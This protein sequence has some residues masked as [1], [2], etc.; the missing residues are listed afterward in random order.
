MRG[1]IFFDPYS[2]VQFY[3]QMSTL[4][5]A[6]FGSLRSIQTCIRQTTEVKL[7]AALERIAGYMEAGHS[8]SESMEKTQGVFTEFHCSM[9][10][11]AEI[12]GNLPEILTRMAEYQEKE[13]NLS[14]RLKSASTYPLFVLAFSLITIILLMNFLTPV[15][16]TVSGVLEGEIPLPTRLLMNVAH[17]ISNPATYVILALAFILVFL[18]YNYY[19][20][21]PQGRYSLDRMKL[22]V[23]LYGKLYRKVILIRMSRVMSQLLSSGVPAARTISL[24]GEVSNNFYVKE[25][26]VDAISFRVEEG[27]PLNSAFQKTDFF[28]KIMTSMI[29]I[30]EQSGGLPEAMS[31][32]SDMYEFDV[33]IAMNT[34]YATLEPILITVMGLITFVILLA[35]FLPI[36][37]IVGSLS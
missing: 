23:P 18:A 8:L 19:S 30:G 26:V 3:R 13:M 24:L 15:L 33:E 10:K 1:R 35:A 32:L 25:R 5:K 29:N 12:S 6:G 36:Y 17:A 34:F 7:K 9:I 14:R 27:E 4:V 28:P 20:S 22:K 31:K 11:A 16:D 21:T 2:L 37:Q